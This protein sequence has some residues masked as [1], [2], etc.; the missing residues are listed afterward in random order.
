[1][2]EI[3]AELVTGFADTSGSGGGSSAMLVITSGLCA[4]FALKLTTIIRRQRS[5]WAVRAC[6][7]W[8]VCCGIRIVRRRRAVWSGLVRGR[9]PYL[10]KQTPLSLVRC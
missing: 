1:M 8:G 10:K 2:A 5:P 6:L 4:G 9:L 3:F 7:L